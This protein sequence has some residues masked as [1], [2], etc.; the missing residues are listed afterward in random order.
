MEPAVGRGEGTS[1]L[2]GG[3][4]QKGEAQAQVGSNQSPQGNSRPSTPLAAF[5]HSR[6]W[7]NR[8]ASP[9]R[10]AIQAA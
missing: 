1:V 6:E 10:P 2:S 9:V 3:V 8:H 4:Y 7:G 5:S